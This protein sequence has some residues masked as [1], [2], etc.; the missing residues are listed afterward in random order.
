MKKSTLILFFL[1]SFLGLQ[2]VQAQANVQATGISIQ[3]IA[4][5]ENNS[6]IANIDQLGL[7][8]KIYYLDGSNNEV[9]ILNQTANVKTDNFGVFSYV[10]SIDKSLFTSIS[11][12][13]AYLKVTQ[14]S[15]VF[16]NEKLQ[17]VPYAIQAQNGVP[18]G[19]IMAYVGATAPEGWLLC[20]GSSFPD[21]VYYAQLKALLGGTNTPNLSARYLRGT[22]VQEGRG[23]ITLKGTQYDEIRQHSH[24][25]N[26]TTTT[27]G[28]HEHNAGNGFN[29]LARADNRFWVN[30][31]STSSSTPTNPGQDP[32]SRLNAYDNA[33]LPFAGDHT[34]QVTGN[35]ISAGSADSVYGDNRP[36][37][38]GVNYIIKI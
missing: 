20:D 17:A 6:A 12:S 5:D 27:N 15:V 33:S 34:H 35:T 29:K 28:N 21:N 16:S 19:A 18:S 10:M 4:R 32:Q 22:G 11:N 3:G 25:I 30:W 23:G 24:G 37:S 14:G 31:G 8:F 9:T 2:K 7:A 13:Q 1:A 38:Y 36:Y 26:I